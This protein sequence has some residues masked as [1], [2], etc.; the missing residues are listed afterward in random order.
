MTG[1]KRLTLVAFAVLGIAVSTA[2]ASLADEPHRH[3]V[4]GHEIQARIDQQISQADADRQAVQIM[5]Q[6][7]A[8]R[9]IA[10]SAGLDIE[11]AVAAAAILSG[12]ALE[13]LA[14]QAREVDASLAGGDTKVVLS[15]TGIIIVLLILI[16][17]L[18]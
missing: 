9:E 1:Y 10:G 8:V 12:P 15:A 2:G 5:L 6:R 16:L 3:V 18:N 17:L 4:S 11:R 14:A 13:K 7:E